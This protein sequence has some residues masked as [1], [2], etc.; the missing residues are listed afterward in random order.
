MTAIL[1][2]QDDRN[3]AVDKR[4]TARSLTAAD[5]GAIRVQEFLNQYR[6]VATNS[7]CVN[8]N[9]NGTPADYQDDTCSD[10][11]TSLQGASSSSWWVPTTLSTGIN[12]VCSTEPA[13][14][15]A[16]NTVKNWA[17]RSWRPVDA[18]DASKGEY[19]IVDYTFTG[20]NS[21]EIA[22][23]LTVQGRTNAGQASE[24]I[25]ELQ[26][27]I[28]IF[29]SLDDLAASLWVRESVT[30]NP[31]IASDV[32]G[33]CGSTLTATVP[34]DRALVRLRT[35]MPAASTPP[36]TFIKTLTTV[37][38][39]TLPETGDVPLD[40]DGVAGSGDE[41]YRYSIQA[42]KIDG[43]FSIQPNTRVDMW[44]T[45][46]S[47]NSNNYAV[48]FENKVI[49]N[50]CAGYETTCGPFDFRIF[51]TAPSNTATATFKMNQ[52]TAVCDVFFHFPNY[53][54]TYSATGTIP[55]QDCG[56]GTENTGIYWVKSWSGAASSGNT[57]DQPRAK[58]VKAYG[59]LRPP[60][61][62]GPIKKWTPQ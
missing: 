36:T 41:I 12:A 27:Q 11:T 59:G 24:A 26:L 25:S 53:A 48:D 6:D 22:G 61:R 34:G 60:H 13:L 39:K 20:F 37:A 57:L 5:T 14:A 18:A 42:D 23:F 62:I 16:Q 32:I 50:P 15:N 56:A 21:A 54:V 10:T 9:T 43:S 40:P 47:T 2:S 58:W 52:G 55:T 30:G 45:A 31:N 44:V 8:W 46:W 35:E 7:I 3:T 49:V 1:R 38:N 17:S 33:P 29:N 4:E 19:R 51:G 28:P